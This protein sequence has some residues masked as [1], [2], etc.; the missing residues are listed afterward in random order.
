M[1]GKDFHFFYLHMLGEPLVAKRNT[2]ARFFYCKMR[3]GSRV[4]LR[5]LFEKKTNIRKRVANVLAGP[6]RVMFGLLRRG[7]RGRCG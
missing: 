5:V 4:G 3:G 6:L 7:L 1:G 2:S